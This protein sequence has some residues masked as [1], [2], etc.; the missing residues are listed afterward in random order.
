[1]QIEDVLNLTWRELNTELMHC[2]DV[3][4]LESWLAAE[5]AAGR[6]TRSK[7][8]LGRL[9][10]VKRA[11]VLAKLPPAA[12]HWPRRVKSEEEGGRAA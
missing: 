10:A 4:Q 1:M 7:R 12:E 6:R 5:M 3:A 11:E 9:W 2:H 8:I